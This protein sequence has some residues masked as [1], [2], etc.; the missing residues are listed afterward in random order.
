ML[1]LMA[2]YSENYKKKHGVY[3]DKL[4]ERCL[5]KDYFFLDL[6][7]SYRVKSDGDVSGV[8]FYYEVIDTNKYYLAGVGKDGKFKT[9][10]DLV[11]EISL[12]EKKTTGLIKYKIKEIPNEMKRESKFH[13]LE[14]KTNNYLH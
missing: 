14:N 12:L 2:K 1:N 4:P 6:D 7:L 8:H 9:D 11:P 5:D 3:P 10:D 13:E